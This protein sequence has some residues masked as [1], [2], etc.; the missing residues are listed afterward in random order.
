MAQERF[1]EFRDDDL[2]KRLDNW[3]LGIFHPGRYCGFDMQVTNNLIV[4]LS[5]TE[6]GIIYNDGTNNPKPALGV[7]VSNVGVVVKESSNITVTAQPNPGANPRIDLIYMQH[8]YRDGVISGEQ[9][10]YGYIQGVAS[11]NPSYPALTDSVNQIVVGYIYWP[12]ATSVI[13]SSVRWEPAKSPIPNKLKWND[14]KEGLLPIV[15]TGSSSSHVLDVA[16]SNNKIFITAE[17]GTSGTHVF[18]ILQSVIT[19]RVNWFFDIEIDKDN[20][21]TDFLLII[22]NKVAGVLTTIKTYTYQDIVNEKIRLKISNSSSGYFIDCEDRETNHSLNKENRFALSPIIGPENLISLTPPANLLIIEEENFPAYVKC[23]ST[24]LDGIQNE[25][26]L[27]PKVGTKIMIEAGHPS[28]LTIRNNSAVT[29]DGAFKFVYG[30]NAGGLFNGP[31]T[32]SNLFLRQGGVCELVYTSAGFWT[33]INNDYSNKL[34]GIENRAGITAQTL[35]AY[36]K[37]FSQSTTPSNVLNFD[38]NGAGNGAD[39]S[40]SRIEM[41]TDSIP[42]TFFVFGKAVFNRKT[43]ASENIQ[44]RLNLVRRNASGVDTRVD[45]GLTEK[46]GPVGYQGNYD[47]TLSVSYMFT[48]TCEVQDSIALFTWVLGDQFDITNIKLNV[49]GIPNS[50]IG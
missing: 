22:K 36:K 33:L 11:A 47:D 50:I 18:E 31:D 40:G 12:A 46:T 30:N 27:T 24:L 7:L 20:L 6:T 34:Q 42:R 48:S 13:N 1:F 3:L 32:V 2:T 10:T 37:F 19:E 44:G 26:I 17:T 8:R 35:A 49:I 9:A 5:H 25:N 41:P 43:V 38:S 39:V 14:Q 29:G 23:L 4:T 45:Q 16:K 28:G 21:L 15:L